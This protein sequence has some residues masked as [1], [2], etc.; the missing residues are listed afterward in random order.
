MK[1]APKATRI[2][3][4]TKVCFGHMA[5]TMEVKKTGT[6]RLIRKMEMLGR[7]NEWGYQWPAKPSV[8]V[9]TNLMRSPLFPTES[10][11]R[12]SDISSY[13]DCTRPPGRLTANLHADCTRFGIGRMP[14]YVVAFN[15]PWDVTRF[16]QGG[17]RSR[18][19]SET[20]IQL[21]RISY[22]D[23]AE[24]LSARPGRIGVYVEGRGERSSTALTAVGSHHQAWEPR[25]LHPQLFSDRVAAA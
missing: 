24:H 20:T 13:K 2:G 14:A 25:L 4:C 15:R 23:S 12:K 5:G 11:A 21:S 8:Q 3:S 7:M 19:F 1:N 9:G 18:D 6:L 22:R 17:M 16:W 10:K